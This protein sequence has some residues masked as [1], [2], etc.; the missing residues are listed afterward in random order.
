MMNNVD[1]WMFIIQCKSNFGFYIDAGSIRW[2][3]CFFF[4]YALSIV[5]EPETHSNSGHLFW[6][7]ENIESFVMTCLAPLLCIYSTVTKPTSK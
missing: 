1:L 5:K 7:V 3:I 4:E 6:N 2:T